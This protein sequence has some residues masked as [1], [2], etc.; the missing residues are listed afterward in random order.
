MALGPPTLLPA[1]PLGA[2]D[3]HRP[4]EVLV[5]AVRARD[6]GRADS[7]EA[8]WARAVRRDP[9]DRLARL[10]LAA[11]ARA[12]SR[13]S[14]ADS[15]LEALGARELEPPAGADAGAPDPVMLWAAAELGEGLRM[16]G[17]FSDM[18]PLFRVADAWARRLA[19]PSLEGRTALGM[20]AW[21]A[22]AGPRDSVG[23]HLARIDA[24]G[25]GVDP[26]IGS[27]MRCQ[28]VSG[29]S[30]SSS[31]IRDR[32][33]AA[34]ASALAEGFP[35]LAA[36]CQAVLHR[37]F[38][39]E[40][41][42]D[43]ALAV[44]GRIETL[45]RASGDPITLSALLERRASLQYSIGALGRATLD[46]RE[47]VEVGERGGNRSAAAW[48]LLHLALVHRATGELDA[49]LEE[50]ERARALFEEQGDES[51]RLV[52]GRRR[53]QVDAVAGR[54]DR[55]TRQLE[56]LRPRMLEISGGVDEAFVQLDILDVALAAG[57]FLRADS[58]LPV[59]RDA[60]VANDQ[61]GWVPGLAWRETAI[62][63]GTGDLPRARESTARNLADVEVGSQRYLG[64]TDLARLRLAEGDVPG[65]AAALE[66][67]LDELDRWRGQLPVERLRVSAFALSRGFSDGVEGPASIVAALAATG[68]VERALALAER[69][70]A[71]TLLENA[72]RSEAVAFGN[73]AG[74]ADL[75]SRVP[76]PIRGSELRAALPPGTAAALVVTGG[77]GEP[78]TAILVTRDTVVAVPLPSTGSLTPPLERF[79][80]GLRSGVWLDAPARELGSAVAGP[81]LA[82]LPPEIGTLVWVPDGPLHALPLDALPLP[83]GG[84]VL[85][86]VAVARAPSLS[87]L[88]ALLKRT[89]VG[90]GRV[91]ALADPGRGP[92]G[93]NP[94]RAALELDAL[95]PLPG[96]RR[97]ASRVAR[98]GRPGEFLRGDRASEAAIRSL[99]SA[100]LGT[101]HLATH[102]VVNPD[103][104]ARTA[105]VLAPGGGEDGLLTPAELADLGL[106][107]DLVVLSACSTGG[108]LTLR[109]EGV[110]GLVAPLLGGGVR[111]A[112]ATGWEIP[113]RMPVP[114]MEGFYAGLS[115][116]VPVAEAMRRA[117][118]E[119]IARGDSPAT[120]AAFQ[121]V[122]DPGV[123]PELA[124][125]FRIP[126]VRVALLALVVVV[127][128]LGG[129][130]LRRLARVT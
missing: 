32:V 4:G 2:Q 126:P 100:P 72:L 47:A 99:A 119:A 44:M 95:P 120:W 127:G 52:A 48:A 23:V 41:N 6:A 65:A 11:L 46:A 27:V 125:R 22:R 67:A 15:L 69:Q 13:Y 113:D 30:G 3:F 55:A 79:A 71:R 102:A 74:S 77:P 58:L 101:L 108:G 75:L 117:K 111:V 45:S 14:R 116:G 109:G 9:E 78:S 53:A 110:Q 62:A 98:W 122:G 12:T 94:L 17:R 20:A 124:L 57:D 10:G 36:D 34:A 66:E 86:R 43:S 73:Q 64:L 54:H 90:G 112:V 19:V 42:A 21:Y 70:R 50:L 18:H 91:V 16:R 105:L 107:A 80:S 61:A 40:G 123:V 59:V 31:D 93:Q 5:E 88:S 121:V 83:E 89:P 38:L 7:L 114:L 118:Q 103:S 106:R 76:H 81:L 85:D 33:E 24:L 1:A 128:I 26:W 96:S 39:S 68:A 97:E 84:R 56:E 35:H 8:V 25:D 130:I 63:L 29:L 37:R 104:P 28:R 82:A 129:G 60:L 92:A 87:V 115:E 49:A 51:G